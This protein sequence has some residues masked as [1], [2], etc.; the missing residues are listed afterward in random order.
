MVKNVLCG[1]QIVFKSFKSLFLFWAYFVCLN[2]FSRCW[3]FNLSSITSFL[4]SAVSLIC[5]ASVVAN[6]SLSFCCASDC[7]TVCRYAHL[8]LCL[9]LPFLLKCLQIFGCLL[10]H[11][12]FLHS[13]GFS[14][15]S[16]TGSFLQG[17]LNLQNQV[18][19]NLQIVTCSWDILVLFLK[20]TFVAVEKE[21]PLENTIRGLFYDVICDRWHVKYETWFKQKIYFFFRY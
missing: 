4:I 19:F 8:S 1:L 7:L 16:L 13:L 15:I 12:S 14:Q 2:I 17:C 9:Q 3:T 5:V 10:V 11:T 18:W 20:I 21:T 6:I